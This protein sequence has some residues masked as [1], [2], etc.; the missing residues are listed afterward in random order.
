MALPFK[1]PLQCSQRAAASGAGKAH[2]SARRSATLVEGLS[3]RATHTQ[4]SNAC[5]T[6]TEQRR[7]DC[8]WS[9]TNTPSCA[10]CQRAVGGTVPLRRSPRNFFDGLIGMQPSCVC[11]MFWN[12]S[13]TGAS[14]TSRRE[15]CVPA[16]VHRAAVRQNIL[17]ALPH[18]SATLRPQHSFQY[19]WIDLA[20]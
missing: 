7:L 18:G 13:G 12:C 9:W 8:W 1:W 15:W 6:A 2:R 10:W 20:R 19:R 3:C 16:G 4:H 17:A 11:C 5:P 14:Q